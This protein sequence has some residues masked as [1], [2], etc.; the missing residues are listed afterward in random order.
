MIT[1][2]ASAVEDSHINV[3]PVIQ[4]SAETTSMA[5]G[6]SIA[7]SDQVSDNQIDKVGPMHQFTAIT[8][9]DDHDLAENH[10]GPVAKVSKRQKQ[11][12]KAVPAVRK[13]TKH[14]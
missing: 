14:R 13:S 8:M 2:S 9:P 11:R 4:I 5:A 7:N 6:P 10:P 1:V 3:Q 12:P